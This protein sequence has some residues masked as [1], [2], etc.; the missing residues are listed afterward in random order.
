MSSETAKKRKRDGGGDEEPGRSGGG[1]GVEKV[2][3][4]MKTQMTRMENR[5]GE[6]ERKCSSLETSLADAKGKCEFFEARCESLESTVQV[7]IKEQKWEYSAPTIPTSHWVDQGFNEDYIEW[8]ELFLREIKAKTC[9]LRSGLC[10]HNDIDLGGANDM[11]LRHNDALLPHWKEFATAL[12]LY[13][14]PEEISLSFSNM[15]LLPAVMN[16]LTPALKQKLHLFK[17]C[18][19]EFANTSEGIE[20]AIKVIHS[21]QK[22]ETLRWV[23]NPIENMGGANRLIEAITSHPVI[24]HI[25][26]ENCFGENANAYELLRVL[27][28]GNKQFIHIDLDSNNLRIGG[29]TEI[30]DLL[31][32]NPPLK[33]LFLENNLLDDKDALQIAHA[34]K[35]NTKL[36]NISLGQNDITDIGRDALRNVI[37]DTT[38][39]NTVANSNHS[40]SIEGLGFEGYNDVDFHVDN[41]YARR[42]KKIYSLLTSRH[43]EGINVRHLNSEFDDESL[44]LVPKVL[45]SVHHYDTYTIPGARNRVHP[46][47]LIYEILRGWKMP[48]LYENNGT[49]MIE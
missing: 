44:K 22:M 25:R 36:Q 1:A 18:N 4:E 37:F 5:M 49:A 13:Q 47:S 16:L 41:P 38:S 9:A 35:Q 23:N 33:D 15:Q 6:L 10:S 26:L 14:N 46:L 31:V 19:N 11:V 42:G 3:A 17:L 45:E 30:P 40:C 34:L 24:D 27:F 7:L 20:F 28:A 48:T 29:F 32:T 21:N 39:L 12:Q 43:R 8:M 2:V